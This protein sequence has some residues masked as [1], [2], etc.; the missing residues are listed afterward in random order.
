ML[1]QSR[2]NEAFALGRERGLKSISGPD[3]QD[4]LLGHG[5]LGLEFS[6]RQHRASAIKLAEWSSGDVFFAGTASGGW[7]VL[8]AAT[9]TR[10][11]EGGWRTT[12]GSYPFQKP[13]RTVP[14]QAPTWAALRVDANAVFACSVVVNDSPIKRCYEEFR[15]GSGP[16]AAG[17]VHTLEKLSPCGGTA[18]SHPWTGWAPAARNSVEEEQVAADPPGGAEVHPVL[19][20]G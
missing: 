3:P 13:S 16:F 4:V 2:K 6:S 10:G 19:T 20:G 14:S 7:S 12:H 8:E 1:L 5:D 11:P 18:S 17:G 9:A 15:G